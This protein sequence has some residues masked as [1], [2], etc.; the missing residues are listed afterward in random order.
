MVYSCVLS[1]LSTC[2]LFR[3][4]FSALHSKELFI[5]Q[6]LDGDSEE[7]LRDMGI[8]E[9]LCSAKNLGGC[10]CQPLNQLLLLFSGQPA[11]FD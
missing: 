1:R 11:A 8:R 6:F 7:L 10:C 9:A 4:R 2:R 5:R 3:H